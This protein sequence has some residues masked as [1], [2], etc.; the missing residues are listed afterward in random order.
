MYIKSGNRSFLLTE[1]L[2][3]E[4]AK[5]QEYREKM[6]RSVANRKYEAVPNGDELYLLTVG[7]E[8]GDGILVNFSETGSDGVYA[9]IPNAKEQLGEH[10]K[11][12]ARYCVSEGTQYTEN[13]QW[14]ITYDELYYHFDQ[15]SI[16][17]RNHMGRL[18]MEELK[19]QDEINELIMTEDCIEITY[20]MEYCESC[21]QNG[22]KGAVSLFSLMGCNLYD[23]HLEHE[24]SDNDCPSISSLNQNQLTEEGKNDWNDVLGAEV[25]S[26]HAHGEKLCIALKN[27]EPGRVLAFS[28]M[29]NGQCDAEDFDRWVEHD[30]EQAE[31]NFGSAIT[32]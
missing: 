29:M 19:K 30:I 2:V 3:M 25:K 24:H 9:F 8:S 20:H 21:N 4:Q 18:L 31:E 15:T 10:I 5:Y 26:I 1:L 7:E 17:P 6:K 27:C 22:I 12:L 16:S 23:V 11:K 28:E 13:G 32:M 14:D